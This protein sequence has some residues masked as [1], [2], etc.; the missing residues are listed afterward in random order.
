MPTCRTS[1]CRRYASSSGGSVGMGDL[2]SG[3]GGPTGD[4]RFAGRRNRHVRRTTRTSGTACGS[5]SCRGHGR[6][7]TS[8]TRRPT[9]TTGR[10]WSRGGYGNR[11]SA[12]TCSSNVRKTGCRSSGTR[13]PT[14]SRRST[15]TTR[16]RSCY[17]GGTGHACGRSGSH[18]HGYNGN[19]AGYIR[20]T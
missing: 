11:P 7:S 9:N 17:G 8:C 19:C 14:S 13:R 6:P 15:G 16:C 10:C 3:F 20:T 1:R 5:S 18:G 2:R 12:R 4:S